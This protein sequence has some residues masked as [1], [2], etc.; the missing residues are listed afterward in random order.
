MTT[1]PLQGTPDPRHRSLSIGDGPAIARVDPDLANA[2]RAK[3]CALVSRCLVK[4]A[5]SVAGND[6]RPTVIEVV[7]VAGHHDRLEGRHNASLSEQRVRSV[8][9]YL[10]RI[11]ISSKVISWEGRGSRDR[12]AVTRFC[13][14]RLLRI[15][16]GCTRLGFPQRPLKPARAAHAR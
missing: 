12:M 3:A 14:A 13:G 2:S 4:T 11:G 15:A 16:A 7:I 10:T 5:Q 6:K 9:D 8:T 1:C